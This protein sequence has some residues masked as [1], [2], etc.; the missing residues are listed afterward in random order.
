[1][2]SDVDIVKSRINIVDI[3]GEY[4]KL[5]KAGNSFKACCPFHQEKTP[6]FNVNEERQMYH[7]FGCGQGGDVFSFVME[8]E[9]IG[10]REAL[11]LLAEKSGVELQ[12]N[13]SKDNDD[14][15]EKKKKLYDA[16][17]SATQFYE[18]QLWQEFDAKNILTYLQERG[19]SGE[20][21]TQFR[22]G[23]A[24]DGWHV[25]ER[26]VELNSNDK[27]SA[28]H[29][30][31]LIKKDNGEFYD[32]FRARIMFPIC[33]VMGRV[34]G[35]TARA[36]PGSDVA[37]AKYINTP[38]T[39]LYHKGNVLYGIHHA[40]KA[41]KDLDS[42]VVVEGN[43][44]VIASHGVG[45]KNV[46]AVSGTAMTDEHIRILKRYTNNF[47]LFF[48]ADTAG[49]NAAR[50][51]AISCL[52]ADVRLKMVLLAEGKDAADIVKE[53]PEKL[54]QI[55]DD[56]KDVV[57]VMSE[58]AQEK[59]NI[60]EPRGKR[61]AVEFVAE[62][63]SYIS[64]EIEKE[65]W[66]IKCAEIFSIEDKFLRNILEKDDD[67]ST[68]VKEDVPQDDVR[69]ELQSDTQAQMKRVYRSIILMMMAYPHV[70]EYVHKN[71]ERYGPVMEQ[72]IIQDLM[73]EGPIIG[74]SIGDFV[75]KDLRREALYKA[76]M[77]LQQK[78]EM[79]REDGGSPIEDTE[80]YIS[81]AY[82]NI[83][84]RRIDYLLKMMNEAEKNDDYGEQK[85]LLEKINNISQQIIRNT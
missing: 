20:I 43:M 18:K 17:E 54:Q 79:E 70:W 78:Y 65:E 84:Q 51:S 15:Q 31:L 11:T 13:Y 55:I 74:F 60:G 23:Y 30:G 71:Q 3:V 19:L 22:L 39:I 49:I 2:H 69:R 34:I 37:Q 52:K 12:N 14:S 4:L 5:I 27:D 75:S 83:M 61:Q 25:L 6:S 66:I 28:L 32:R 76:A 47:T 72:T 85:R 33:D 38:E 21:I 24:P 10:F 58:I 73:R 7:C 8:M 59:F 67:V 68:V 41:I 42:V 36:L 56:A 64:N 57:L 9:N 1:M 81:I 46:I 63:I 48:D 26:S 35:F 50:R 82:E 44:D 29:A 77:K 16:T 45:V 40:K 53:K 62:I 80:T